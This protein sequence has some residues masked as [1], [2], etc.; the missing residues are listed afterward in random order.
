MLE[1][2]IKERL[3][4]DTTIAGLTGGRIRPLIGAQLD[5]RP[6]LTFQVT[7]DQSIGHALGASAYSNAQVEIGILADTYLACA[8]LSV[9]VKRVLDRQAYNT[10]TVR[11]APSV[12]DD[13]TDIEEST[14]PGQAAPVFVRTQTY[15]VLYRAI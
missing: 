6:F 7:S 4:A 12:L 8:A 14:P 3:A 5:A 11:I 1:Q 15:R 10:T 13:E 9:E 2:G